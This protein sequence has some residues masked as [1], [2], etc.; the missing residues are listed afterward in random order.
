MTITLEYASRFTDAKKHFKLMGNKMLIERIELGEVKTKSGL[1]VATS[2]KVRED[3][4]IQ[5]PH[6]GYVLATGEGYF[7]A[8]SKSTV[9]LDVKP[10]NIVVLNSLGVQ[11]LKTMPGVA[12]YSD[13]KIGMT[14]EGDVQMLFHDM[15]AFLAYVQA[16][17]I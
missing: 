2:D 1:V 5:K 15:D 11:Y 14:T 17:G 9:P 12:G 3:L 8:D 16:L 10:G 7:D 13:Q 6:V 4:R